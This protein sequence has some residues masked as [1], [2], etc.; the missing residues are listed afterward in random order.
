MHITSRDQTWKFFNMA[1]QATDV[2]SVDGLF[3][4]ILPLET[5]RKRKMSIPSNEREVKK[6]ERHDGSGK[7]PRLACT[8]TGEKGFCRASMLSQSD[9]LYNF[10]LFYKTAEK[11]RQDESILR[12]VKISQPKRPRVKADAKKKARNLSV[13]YYL[14]RC[15]SEEK[16]PVCKATFLSVLGISNDRAARVCR[17][18]A[19]HGIPRPELRGGARN[20][21]ENQAKR[22]LVRQHISQFQCQ[23][24]HYGRDDCPGRRYISSDLSVAKMYSLFQEQNHAQVSYGLYY[25]VFKKDFNLGFGPPATEVCSICQTI[26]V[27]VE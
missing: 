10:S 21:E 15:N 1:V 24:S 5:L 18:F 17:Y 27:E 19:M 9:L 8:H 11:K 13:E 7:E 26:K 3:E 4:A 25:S 16:I 14:M 6:I 22:E 20:V 2:K 23:A 12:H